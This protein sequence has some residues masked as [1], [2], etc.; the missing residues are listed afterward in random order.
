MVLVDLMRLAGLLF[1]S[2]ETLLAENLFLRRQ[3]AL[4]KERGIKP[5][6][7]GTATRGSLAI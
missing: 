5:R 7:M 3:L 2:R 1:V 4:C 6:R